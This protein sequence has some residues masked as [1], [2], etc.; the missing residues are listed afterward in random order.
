MLRGKALSVVSAATNILFMPQHVVLR[1]NSQHGVFT[2][3]PVVI[4]K[5]E[6]ARCHTPPKFSR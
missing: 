4:C 1:A 5:E 6:Q 3:L 2:Q